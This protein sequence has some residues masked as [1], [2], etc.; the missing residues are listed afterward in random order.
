MSEKAT[1][2]QN[3]SLLKLAG[4]NIRLRRR[5]ADLEGALGDIRYAVSDT[6]RRVLPGRFILDGISRIICTALKEVTDA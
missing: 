1:L 3:A 4:E 2:D 5:V 6:N